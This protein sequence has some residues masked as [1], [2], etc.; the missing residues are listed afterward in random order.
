MVAGGK[1][2]NIIEHIWQYRIS[3]MAESS[4][5]IESVIILWYFQC[6]CLEFAYVYFATP[7]LIEWIFELEIGRNIIY[8]SIQMCTKHLVM[9]WLIQIHYNWTT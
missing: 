2:T 1:T 7:L 9:Q 3:K 4:T 8:S 6:T 5:R